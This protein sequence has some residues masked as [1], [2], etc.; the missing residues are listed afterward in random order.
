MGSCAMKVFALLVLI[1]AVVDAKKRTSHDRKLDVNILE[2]LEDEREAMRSGNTA[3]A[4]QKFNEALGVMRQIKNA[5]FEKAEK[6]APEKKEKKAAKAP[7]K[8]AP[9][10]KEAKKAAKPVETDQQ[11]EPK[12]EEVKEEAASPEGADL[13]KDSATATPALEKDDEV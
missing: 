2:I 5:D 9:K 3:L 11:K 12:E 1:A 8:A 10:A 4:Q 13:E 7:S 6:A